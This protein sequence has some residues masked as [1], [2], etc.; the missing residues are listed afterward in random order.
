[1]KITCILVPASIVT[2]FFLASCKT[3]P[4][5]DNIIRNAFSDYTGSF[6]L[7]DSSSGII[8]DFDPET[9]S[10]KL[11]PCSTFKIWNTLIGF[12][13][14][15][16]STPNEAFY[17]WD[18]ETRF[19][20]EW[21]QDLTLREAFRASC[22][23]AFQ[24]LARK[25]GHKRMQSWL[26][27]I[28]Y[29]DRNISA[30]IDAFWLPSLGRKTLL[31]TPREQATLMHKLVLGKLPFSEASQAKL[32]D[33]MAIK[34]THNGVLYGKTGSRIDNAGKFIMGWF[35]GYVESEGKTYA[36]ACNVKG[37]SVMGK[38]AIAIVITILEKRGIL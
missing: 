24:D 19:I 22:V 5:P 30:G 11:P 33:V 18:G 13:S 36:F 16:I 9:S 3:T 10:E 2:M 23:P 37:N 1:M 17:E 20:Q 14:G 15:I 29:G 8:S 4:A 6:V 38:D 27:K 26:D 31:I 32:K 7:I 34:N 12:E 21:N 25:I 28:G 35:V